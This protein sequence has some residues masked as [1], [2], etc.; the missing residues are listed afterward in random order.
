MLYLIRPVLP[1]IPFVAQ[2]VYTKRS[3]N[4]QFGVGLGVAWCGT[5]TYASPAR[6][7]A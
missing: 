3:T 7:I 6:L 1:L 5:A 4:R 2:R